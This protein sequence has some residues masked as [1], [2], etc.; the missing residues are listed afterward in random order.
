MQLIELWFCWEIFLLK[1]ITLKRNV[2][3]RLK[4]WKLILKFFNLF[5]SVGFCLLVA[6]G[7]STV[8]PRLS[9]IQRRRHIPRLL[10]RKQQ[11]QQQQQQQHSNIPVT[12]CYRRLTKCRRQRL[13]SC[14][15]RDSS[16]TDSSEDG[17]EM[18]T[19]QQKQHLRQQQQQ[20]PTI[21]V[22][23]QLI[24]TLSLLVIVLALFST[25]TWIKNQ[26]WLSRASLFRYI[27]PNL[28]IT[29]LVIANLVITNS[30]ITNSFITTKMFV[31]LVKGIFM[32]KF[33]D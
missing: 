21:V 9:P 27:Q 8:L 30:G 33:T 11:Q 2:I 22:S 13:D 10:L 1:L 20:Q 4:S 3:T 6:L 7:L 25:K 15:S 12:S 28:V 29:N 26:D 5:F 14:S 18:T 16:V 17:C 24:L 19:Q 23:P 31:R 32:L